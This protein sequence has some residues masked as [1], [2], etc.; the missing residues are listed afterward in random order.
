[1]LLSMI[2]WAYSISN[3]KHIISV[4]ES[5]KP[6]SL[7]IVFNEFNDVSDVAIQNDTDFI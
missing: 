3:P 6:D 7:G 2:V 5:Q 1:M 4:F